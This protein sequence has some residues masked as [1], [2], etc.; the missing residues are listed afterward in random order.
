MKFSMDRESGMVE[1]SGLEP[2]SEIKVIWPKIDEK[3]VHHSIQ[4][5][6][7][8]GRA[9]IPFGNRREMFL[10]QICT[11]QITHDDFEPIEIQAEIRMTKLIRVHKTEQVKKG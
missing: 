4:P 8:K 2:G 5:V 10:R 1:F 3:G 9:I 7:K 6:D 11:I